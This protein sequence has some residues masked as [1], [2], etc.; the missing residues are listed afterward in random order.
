MA[1]RLTAVR[2][3]IALAMLCG[4]VGIGTAEPT[5]AANA[6][7][8]AAIAEDSSTI[9]ADPCPG[10]DELQGSWDCLMY[11]DD[12]TPRGGLVLFDQ[13]GDEVKLC[14]GFWDDK[15]VELRVGE[16]PR[17]RLEVWWGPGEGPADACLTMKYYEF[18]WNQ[19]PK[20]NL[21]EP[22]PWLFRICLV[23]HETRE[24]SGCDS[25]RWITR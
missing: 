14:D 11:T 7:E 12:P 6:T 24:R 22:G 3:V 21:P 20:Y 15:E 5:P 18:P 2:G 8:P 19:W 17:Y 9:A 10:D 4:I 23:D 25:A 1:R 13:W 16:G